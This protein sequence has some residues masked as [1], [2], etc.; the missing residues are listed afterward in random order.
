[1][2]SQLSLA[3][4]I[5]ITIFACSFFARAVPAHRLDV[6]T[7]PGFD[8][9]S[10]MKSVYGDCNP[11]T[12]S[13]TVTTPEGAA[14]KSSYFTTKQVIVRPFFATTLDDASPRKIFLLTYATPLGQDFGCHACAPLIAAFVFSFGQSRW[15]VTASSNASV[16]FGQ[17]GHPPDAS[18]VKI[19]PHRY[20]VE[21]KDTY[22]DK[23]STRRRSLCSCRGRA[24]LGQL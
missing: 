5:P 16:V 21:L 10:A 23:V 3:S 13:C 14:R 1:M 22:S 24:L 15:A 9:G 7:P 4:L 8:L 12:R 6:R 20:G 18:K 19:G 11:I 2:P 17:W